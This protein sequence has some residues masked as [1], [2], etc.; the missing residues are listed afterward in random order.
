MMSSNRA[1][2]YA[3]DA[4]IRN[5]SLLATLCLFYDK[6]LLPYPYD[7]DP[8]CR[9]L[10]L[11]PFDYIDELEIHQKYYL[12]WK[13]T[14]NQLFAANI[15][16][17]LPPPVRAEEEPVDL[18][19]RLR[20][21]LGIQLP[22]FTKS[23]T[24]DGHVAVAM[25][26][27]FGKTDAPEFILSHPA[28]TTTEHL[29]S[30]LAT[31]LIEYRMPKIGALDPEQIIQ[32]REETAPIREEFILYLNTLVDDVEGRLTATEG[33][34]R[35]AALRTVK[36]RME[37]ELEEYLRRRV[38]EKIRW[39]SE[40]IRK[41]S[42][43]TG[44]VLKCCVTRWSLKSV[45]GLAEKLASIP[46]DIAARISEQASNQHRAFQFLGSFEKYKH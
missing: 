12:D 25:H 2:V 28:D 22:Y 5:S 11:W 7:L 33:D 15:I 17:V 8:E 21:R 39:W 26:A 6:I 41:I 46:E 16:Q 1:C 30:T 42:A 23:D 27:L 13:N 10:M 9:E 3:S 14:W 24:F 31:T 43:A 44:E 45:P 40:I 36:R 37:P 29:A 35:K 4:Y 32:L 38:P 34:E 19:E 18:G 20:E